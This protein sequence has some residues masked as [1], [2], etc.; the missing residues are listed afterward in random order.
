MPDSFGRTK[1]HPD[2]LSEREKGGEVDGGSR[3][4]SGLRIEKRIIIGIVCAL[5]AT[6]FVLTTTAPA[7]MAA[8]AVKLDV[9]WYQQV[10]DW[11]CGPASVQI[12]FDYWGEY[13]DQREIGYAAGC[14]P[15]WTGTNLS[16]MIRA[17]HYSDLSPIDYSNCKLLGY[18]GRGLGYAAFAYSSSEFWLDGLKALL[19]QGYP[20]IVSGY[21][22]FETSG[23]SNTVPASSPIGHFRVVVGYD[24]AAGEVIINDPWGRDM[25]NQGDNQGSMKDNPGYNSEFAGIRFS[26]DYFKQLWS[27]NFQRTYSAVF[28]APWHIDVTQSGAG[29]KLKVTATVTYPC[30]E[31]FDRATYPASDVQVSLAVPAGLVLAKGESAVKTVNALSAGGSLQVSWNLV[32]VSAGPHDVSVAAQGLVSGSYAGIPYTDRIGGEATATVTISR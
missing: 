28:L 3:G 8:S 25:K 6:M 10:N 23:N 7:A 24:D 30:P 19:D 22:G 12:V 1:G 14:R 4:K 32:G 17:G 18:T 27:Y 21:W 2:T 15:S 16:G 9:P 20:V 31:P 11:M 29:T 13:I 26:Y 5:I